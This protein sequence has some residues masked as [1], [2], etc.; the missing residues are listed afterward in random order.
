M[1]TGAE[2]VRIENNSDT[3][4]GLTKARELAK[5]NKAVILDINIDYSKATAFTEGVVKTNLNRMPLPT[6]VRMVGRA[7]IR[8]VTG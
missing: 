4:A 3:K 6:K 8:K 1:A 2:Y 5:K 7:M